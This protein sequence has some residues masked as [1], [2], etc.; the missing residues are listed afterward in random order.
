MTSRHALIGTLTLGAAGMFVLAFDFDRRY[1]EAAVRA[2]STGGGGFP[3]EIHRAY[4]LMLLAFGALNVAALLLLRAAFREERCRTLQR[5]REAPPE[6]PAATGSLEEDSA[7]MGPAAVV[8]VPG[9]EAWG[10][11]AP[12][13]VEHEAAFTQLWLRT[14]QRRDGGWPGSEAAFRKVFSSRELDSEASAVAL[15]PEGRLLGAL[16]ALRQ[17]VMEDEGYWWLEVPGVIGA[18]MVDPAFRLKGIARA[19]VSRCEEIARLRKRPRL[20]AGGLENFTQL[21]PGIPGDDYPSRMF[22]LAMGYREVRK[23]CHMEARMEGYQVPQE[24]RERETRLVGEGYRFAAAEATDLAAFGAFVERVGLDRPAR[25]LEKYSMGFE[26]FYFVWK[27]DRIAG[28]LQVSAVEDGVGG[29]SGLYFSRDHRG[30]GLGSVLLVKAHEL[31]ARQGV[32]VASI[33]TYPEAAARFYPRAGFQLVQE[34]VQY[35]K[36]FEHTWDDPA[37]VQRWR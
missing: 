29:M 3:L 26:R 7:L 17:P 33:W 31:W 11:V 20:F 25:R 28:Y 8:P 22:F 9:K 23:T 18:V 4:L 32:K 34:W 2:L 21:V 19:L 27:E 36:E 24:L 30:K 16:L 15:S 37:F 14:V 10:S 6:K 35:E 12:W 13:S 1:A 5:L